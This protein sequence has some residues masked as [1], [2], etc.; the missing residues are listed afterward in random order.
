MRNRKEA[1]KLTKIRIREVKTGN[2]RE[3][4]P[5]IQLDETTLDQIDKLEVYEADYKKL[6]SE[7]RA[8]LEY[9]TKDRVMTY[10]KVADLILAFRSKYE[11]AGLMK[12]LCLD[13]NIP[14]R[15]LSYFLRFRQEY[16]DFNKT[17]P[18]AYYIELLNHLPKEHRGEF[19]R[20]IVLGKIK[21]RD[22][23]RAQIKSYRKQKD[24]RIY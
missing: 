3:R 23:L 4:I 15:T 19:E 24:I 6:L 13:L 7:C 1:R 20:R 18:W 11:A 17:I 12:T 2:K 10:W 9:V 5:T 16:E 22:D 8:L 14:L 21:N